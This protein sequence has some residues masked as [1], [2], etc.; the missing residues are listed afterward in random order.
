MLS[1]VIPAA[2]LAISVATIAA[3]LAAG[4]KGTER[5]SNNAVPSASSQVARATAAS[6]AGGGA[7]ATD[8]ISDRADKGRIQGADTARVW[9]IEASDFQCPYCKTFHDST[10]PKIV[11]DYVATGKIRMAY[12]NFPLNIHPNAHPAAEAA[13]CASVQGKFWP[14][15]DLLFQTQQRWASLPVATP[16]FDSLATA[17]GITMP[18]WRDCVS[19]HLT[20]AII[21]ADHERSE[22]AGVQSTPSFF[23]GDEAIAGAEE[24]PKFRDAIERALAKARGARPAQ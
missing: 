19:K 5:A 21:Q 17:L 23:I 4:C 22:R 15:H 24:Y 16:V 20:N 12:L 10:Y 18:A 13:M 2:R 11:R 3:A 1:P 7:G 9:L 6:N 14:M 8:S